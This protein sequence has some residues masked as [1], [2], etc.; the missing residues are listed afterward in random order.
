MGIAA[1]SSPRRRNE[2][3]ARDGGATWSGQVAALLIPSLVGAVHA[4]APRSIA[5]EARGRYR[6]PAVLDSEQSVRADHADDPCADK[7]QR[8]GLRDPCPGD[9]FAFRA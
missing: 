2:R 6:R 7:Q 9:I 3:E 8:R 4:G 5:D 1:Q